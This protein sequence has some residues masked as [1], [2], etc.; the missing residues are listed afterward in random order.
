MCIY[1][2]VARLNIASNIR[3]LRKAKG[4]TQAALAAKSGVSNRVLQ[5]IEGGHAN[6]TVDTIEAIADTLGVSVPEIMGAKAP[7]RRI[8]RHDAGAMAEAMDVLDRLANAPL[9]VQALVA[10]LIDDDP[11]HLSQTSREF[12]EKLIQWLRE[13]D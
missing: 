12:R 5:D 13:V 2:R 1:I 3:N 4:L 7:V 9:D 6:P 11:R 10:T 8:R